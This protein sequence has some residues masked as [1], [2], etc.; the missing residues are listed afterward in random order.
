MTRIVAAMS[1]GVDSS[2]A[3][4]L[5][6]RD[7]R[8]GG[9]EVVG[10]WMRT[11]PDRGEGW[12]P[13]R[14]CCSTEAADDARRVADRIGIPFFILN[15]EAEFGAQVI[16]AFADAYLDGTTPNPC[17][18]CNQNI[19]FDLLAR[20][21]VGAYGADGV[22]TGHYA[23][24]QERDGAWRLLRAHD[25]AKDQT[26]FLWNLDQRQ[27]AATRFPLGEMTK[28]EVRQLAAD[29]ELPTAATPESQEIC[30]VPAGDY[31]ALLAE[32][33]A[34]EGEA[35]P[36]VDREGQRVGTHT[37]YAHYTIGQRRGLGLA[38]GEARY[39]TEI[40]PDTNE[41]VVGDR[42]ALATRTVVADA[43][44]FVAGAAPADRFEAQVRIRHRSPDVACEV[45]LVGADRLLIETAEPVWGP[46]P[47]QSAV[48]YRDD[49]CLGG[50]RI[51]RT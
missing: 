26:Y 29:L 19:K 37:G 21:A 11:H 38:T 51:A 24:V 1:G 10:V 20:R 13:R 4:A 30:F 36:I 43:R 32:R 31:R 40:R 12:E 42:D 9:E 5:L 27:L 6:A 47:G 44:H 49:E 14:G 41:V 48:L 8:A 28:P 2:V 34:Y 16:D 7:A 50:G 45:T 33:R 17:Q 3:A 35:G 23:R 25:E 22:A 15:V 39:V 18:A 46:A